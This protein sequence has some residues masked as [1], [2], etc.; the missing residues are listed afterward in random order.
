MSTTELADYQLTKLLI[1]LFFESHVA[2]IRA[3]SAT[4]KTSLLNNF[5][6]SFVLSILAPSVTICD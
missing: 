6:H 3:T 5:K 4:I 1:L 2:L